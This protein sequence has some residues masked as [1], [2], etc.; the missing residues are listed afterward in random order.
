MSDVRIYAIVPASLFTKNYTRTCG[1]TVLRA[2][3]R[4]SETVRM[5]SVLSKIIWVVVPEETLFSDSRGSCINADVTG[6]RDLQEDDLHV[7]MI[8]EK[9]DGP[10]ARELSLQPLH[11]MGRR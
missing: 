4:V 1:H 2:L 3:N 11:P 10:R 5:S 9:M 6:W 8:E 7:F